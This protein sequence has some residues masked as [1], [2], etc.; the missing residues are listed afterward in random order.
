MMNPCGLEILCLLYKNT[1]N[2]AEMISDKINKFSD[3]QTDLKL[4]FTTTKKLS[5]FR[6]ARETL[7]HWKNFKSIS[8]RKYPR[9]A[10]KI[11]HL[12]KKGV[13][14]YSL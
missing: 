3:A 7:V 8:P 10:H 12:D 1:Y 11:V 5:N 6:V 14:Y 2:S 9:I 13:G 4:F